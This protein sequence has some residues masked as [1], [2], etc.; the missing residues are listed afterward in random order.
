[1]EWR[2][3][4][5]TSAGDD[6]SLSLFG[7]PRTEERSPRARIE[8]IGVPSDCGNGAASGARFGPDAIRRASQ[9][10]RLE[11]AGVDRGDVEGVHGYDWADVLVRAQ[12]AIEPLVE[13][14]AIPIVLGGDHSVS[15]AAV[16]ALR[17]HQT[18]NIVWFDAH[19]DFCAWPGGR[20]H[21]HKQVLRR[22]AGLGH[23]GRILQIGHRGI[24]YFDESTRSDKMIVMPAN[25]ALSTP[26]E[27]VPDLLPEGEPVYISVD[28]DAIDPRLAPGTG[29]PVPGGLSG[30]L[31]EKMAGLIASRRRVVGFDV[32]EV[33]PLLDHRDVTSVL[34]ARLL[35]AIV[36]ILASGDAA[37]RTPF[38]PS[39]ED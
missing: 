35:A 12:Q 25:A 33:N 37:L 26:P 18:L 4:A 38:P 14:G 6:A 5:T 1:M 24:T 19:T 39:R 3:E 32:M 31:V 28:V 15:Y 34:A 23:V 22:I 16:A 9:S 27:S 10:L 20:W 17:C 29:H 36:P 8:V 11:V 2:H 13:D 30:E 21:D 7:W